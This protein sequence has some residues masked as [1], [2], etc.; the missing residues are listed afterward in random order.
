MYSFSNWTTVLSNFSTF[1]FDLNAGKFL[2]VVL[3]T[4]TSLSD[5]KADLLDLNFLSM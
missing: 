3:S 4:S 5:Y 2:S 1:N